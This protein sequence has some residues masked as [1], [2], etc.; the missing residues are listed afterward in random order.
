M[1]FWWYGWTGRSKNGRPGHDGHQNDPPAPQQQASSSSS[2]PSNLKR[3]NTTNRNGGKTIRDLA[4]M[5]NTPYLT[6]FCKVIK[7]EDVSTTKDIIVIYSKSC[8]KNHFIVDKMRG[9]SYRWNTTTRQG[10][11][12]KIVENI[13]LSLLQVLDTICATIHDL[14]I[15]NEDVLTSICRDNVKEAIVTELSNQ[16]VTYP[17]TTL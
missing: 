16:H 5:A 11:D 10:S 9:H 15:D 3:I 14:A 1:K 13:N 8:C 7:K 17:S 2:L 12:N 4:T 6:P